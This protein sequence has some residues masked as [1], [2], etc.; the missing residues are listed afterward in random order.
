MLVQLDLRRLAGAEPGIM[1]GK[2]GAFSWFRPIN[3]CR[4][5]ACRNMGRAVLRVYAVADCLAVE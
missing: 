2:Y 4:D 1:L 3:S 5:P